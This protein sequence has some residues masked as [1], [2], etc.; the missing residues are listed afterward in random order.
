MAK[1]PQTPQV[2]VRNKKATHKFELLERLECGIVLKGTE[3]KSLRAHT[4]NLAEAYV[5]INN[6][7]MWLI[8]CHISPYECGTG[9]NHEP[10]R[11]RK[12]L[13][14]G[15]EIRRWEPKVK[16]QG[17]TVVPL[18]IHFNERGIAK[19]SVALASGKT[20]GDKRR[21]LKKADHQR[22]MQRAMRR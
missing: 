15:R 22:E 7:E 17:L 9:Q 10:I 20:H 8:G 18:D 11:K 14:H 3:V 6:G 13:A 4:V 21:D 1:K 5:Q 2:V 19:V 16:T 12:L